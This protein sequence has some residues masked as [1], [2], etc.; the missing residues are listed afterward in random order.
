MDNAPDHK[1]PL[2]RALE[3]TKDTCR[4]LEFA[5][6]RGIVHRDLK[7]GNVWLTQGS[8]AKI[9]DF[10][11]AVALDRSRLTA[12]GMMV[13]TVAY[14]P[15]EQALGGEVT[16]RSDLYSL[17]A[18]LYEM[19]CGRPPFLGDG[20]V[21]I[22]GQHINTPPVAPIWHNG[23][24][25][26]ALEAMVMRLLAKD[27][28][29]RPASATDVLS[30]LEAIDVNVVADA[31]VEQDEANALDSLAGGVFVGRHREMGELKAA[32]EDALSGRGRLVT[33]VGEPGIG[34]TR[35]AQELATYAGLRQC[36]VL[37]GRC[38]EGGGA[39]PYWPWVQA[40]RSEA[41][42]CCRPVS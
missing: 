27:P 32:L 26:R 4:G 35:T 25:P 2:E 14:M 33:L 37:W 34:K 11:L 13:D 6:S 19:V 8:I 29:E 1:L 38:Y 36:Q 9:G 28:Q 12:E 30:A 24:C 21:S 41:I 20:P 16:P 39:P 17:G 23:N 22:I 31:T 7:P 5:R 3:I 15:P 40:I 10:G 42:S 18:M